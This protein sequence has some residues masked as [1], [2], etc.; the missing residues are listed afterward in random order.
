M[1]QHINTSTIPTVLIFSDVCEGRHRPE[2]LENLIEPSILY[3]PLVQTMQCHP[4]TKSKMK[5]CLGAIVKREG[6]PPLPDNFYEEIQSSSHG[7][8]RHAIMS[9]QFNL[10]ATHP[11]KDSGRVGRK[12]A[13][14]L[15]LN[16]YEIRKSGERD[17][18][19][20]SFHALGKLL[21][22]KRQTQGKYTQCHS[23][24]KFRPPLQFDPE[25]VIE[26]NT[27]SLSGVV[28]FLGFHSPDFFTDITELSRAFEQFSDA[29]FFL[30][31]FPHVRI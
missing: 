12:G 15:F 16:K 25:K 14:N 24:M 26:E 20:S 13:D 7:D 11:L 28:S 17:Q 1:K 3:S 4:V 19:L 22:A 9:A 2:D 27:M 23:N 29:A 10:A 31:K 6:L 21:Y 18:T 30:D 5:K 8:L